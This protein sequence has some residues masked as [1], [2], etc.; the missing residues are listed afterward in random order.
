MKLKQAKSNRKLSITLSIVAVLLVLMTL[1]E[2]WKEHNKV[3]KREKDDLELKTEIIDNRTD[4]EKLVKDKIN[5]IHS[6]TVFNVHIVEHLGVNNLIF[7]YKNLLEGR[8][9]SDNFFIHLFLKDTSKI[10]N[11]KYINLDF[12][13]KKVKP[14]SILGKEYF[15]FKKP[16]ISS[17]FEHKYIGLDDIK[18]INTGRYKPGLNRSQSVS[19]LSTVG[20]E[21]VMLS[22]TLP[23]VNI[24]VKE[25][26]FKKIRSKR[27]EAL[28]NGILI[29]KND[30]IIKGRISLNNEERLEAQFRL[31]GDL[32]DH[33]LTANKWSYRFIMEGEKTLRG[34]RKFSIQHPKVRN[35]VWEWLFHR[36]IKDNN[37]IGLR[38]DFI[39]VD[40]NLQHTRD[41]IEK[42]PMG[43]MAFEESFD[44][45]LIENNSQREGLILAFDESLIWKDR[46]KQ[47]STGLE[48]TARSGRLHSLSS[49][50][51]K[52]F[53]RNKVLSD[54]KLK[55]QFNI[56]KDLIDGLRNEKYKISEV[57][58]IDKLTT[59]IALS[60]L[61]GAHH[62]LI[63]HNLRIYYN[64]VTNKLEPISFDMNSGKRI[65][66]LENYPLSVGD[67]QYDALL[68]KK[69]RQV[70]NTTFINAFIEKYYDEIDRLFIN[71]NTEFSI[72]LD[73]SILEYNSNFIKKQ[74]NPS[75]VLTAGLIDFNKDQMSLEIKNLTSYDIEMKGLVNIKG[76]KLSTKVS[77]ELIKPLES[78][79]IIFQ[80]NKYFDNAFVS[81]KN[82][83]GGFRYPKDVDKILLQYNLAGVDYIREDYLT[84]YGK[85]QNIDESVKNYRAMFLDNYEEFPFVKKMGDSIIF[86]SGDYILNKNMVI[87][88]GHQI[89]IQK[90]FSLDF[91]DKSS[92]ISYSSIIAR[93]SK[94]NPI[95]FFS[96][97]NLGGG[98]FISKSDR[99]SEFEQCHFSNLSYPSVNGWELSG[100]VNF[101]ESNV[102]ISNS[103]FVNNRSEDG[104]NIIRSNFILEKSIF[105]NTYSD[106]FDGDFVEGEIKDCEFLNCGNDGIDISGSNIIV[107]NVLIS[108][109][110]DKAISAGEA[111]SIIGSDIE[112]QGGEIGIVSKDLS[113]VELSNVKISKTRLG[114]SSFQKKTE[115][116]RGLIK[117]FNLKME[118]VQLDYLVE[119][120][121]LFTI[122]GVPVQTVSNN[123]IDQ[124]YGKE[125]GK[126]SR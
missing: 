114:L 71:L 101:H 41:S 92:L 29:T 113:S 42:I 50:P 32:P 54:P 14:I 85:N 45:I 28:A 111:S 18:F 12:I 95:R 36:V 100:A 118:D 53:N 104:L 82:K 38:Y 22:N 97:D 76:R 117:I 35:Y 120:G 74:I 19:N 51:L 56:A 7:I 77:S 107:Q 73:L 13:P 66:K 30:D 61:F 112:I 105:K 1:T 87:P 91:K 63:W 10:V 26:N 34:L 2:F 67:D 75:D 108:T 31:K 16:L 17:N 5:L 43:I 8:Q 33:L 125:Y 86:K 58:D 9:E 64:P 98:I 39:D 65:V 78:K 48:P 25:K 84:P 27:E 116:G 99:T 123:V 96:S 94:E 37:I 106:A 23:K 15:I 110:L 79:T 81:K 20:L 72:E 70:S 62:G 21:N 124:M 121:S 102:L 68:L 115:Y 3:S 60:N 69:L 44:K 55:K 126:S 57:F 11:G 122:D 89:V 6:D 119:N 49:A 109:P 59:F 40:L 47:I 80:L 93:G 52:V 83:K 103:S 4:Y 90:D 24:Y 88:S 46:K